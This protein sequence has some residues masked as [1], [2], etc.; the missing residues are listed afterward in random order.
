MTNHKT[1]ISALI[2]SCVE[3]LCF[4]FLLAPLPLAAGGNTILI[5][6]AAA[7]KGTA[8]RTAALGINYPGASLKLSLS[9]SFA[10]ELRGQYADTIFAG[11]AR[12]YYYPSVFGVSNASLRPFLC[13]EGDYLSFKSHIS[14][15]SGIAFGG[16][17]GIEYFLSKRLSVQTD[18]GP[19]YVILKDK[20]S[21][22]GL[23]GL[24]FV[25]NFGINLYFR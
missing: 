2:I 17:G 3:A 21:S 16:S 20:D 9:D 14:K 10:A 1:G 23:N 8:G 12:L 6:D 22:V 15:G 4:L 5:G 18:V 11:G 7:N 13:V 25:L 24:Q 19:V